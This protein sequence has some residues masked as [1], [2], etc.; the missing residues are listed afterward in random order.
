MKLPGS[1]LAM[2]LGATIALAER[3]APAVAGNPRS[4][5]PA[6]AATGQPPVRTIVVTSG[7]C[8]GLQDEEVSQEAQ[9]QAQKQL[10]DR[11][12]ELAEQLSGY[13]PSTR[14]IVRERGWLLEQPGVDEQ[15]DLA[16]ETKEYGPVAEHTI[17]LSL[18]EAVVAQWAARLVAE[19][20]RQTAL[21]LGA[22]AATVVAWLAGAGVLVKL[23]RATNGYHTAMLALAVFGVL[24]AASGLGWAW[25]VAWR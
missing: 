16:A 13:R 10:L 6:G 9:Q 18:P 12:A 3:E 4:A 14:Q 7:R 20:R 23:D 21:T 19:H 25:L 1:M 2:L 17:R 8:V 24:L 15:H 5:R 11:L 22:I